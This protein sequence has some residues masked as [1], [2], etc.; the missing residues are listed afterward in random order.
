MTPG[1]VGKIF[2]WWLGL[3]ALA[4]LNG[5]LREKFLIPHFGL[6]AAYVSSGLLLCVLVLGVALLVTPTLHYKAVNL[7]TV[8]AL[9]LILT[10]CFEFTFGIGIQHKSLVEVMHAYTFAAGNLWPIVLL[11][12]FV[13]PRLAAAIRGLH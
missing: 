1:V 3:L 7:W 12:I 8:G 2:L 6:L 4:I 11:M 5:A 10:L 9:W 13:G